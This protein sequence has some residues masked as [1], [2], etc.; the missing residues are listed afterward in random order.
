MD[1]KRFDS[2]VEGRKNKNKTA[3]RKIISTY[4]CQFF[5]ADLIDWSIKEWGKK[6]SFER[7]N[8]EY[9]YILV[10]VDAYSRYCW[11][12]NI[13]SKTANSIIVAFEKIF[14]QNVYNIAGSIDAITLPDK[15][16]N[17]PQFLVTDEGKEFVNS[18]FKAH[19][20]YN[21]IKHIVLKGQSKAM[22]AE[23]VI[24]D[25]KM[26]LR[27]KWNEIKW[28]EWTQPFCDFYN[29]KYHSV[30]KETPYNVFVNGKLPAYT[31]N[32]LDKK[33]KEKQFELADEVRIKIFK[34]ALDKKSLKNNWSTKIYTICEIDDRYEPI[35]YKVRDD[36]GN[37]LKRKFYHFELMKE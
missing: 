18:T 23:R 22:L 26:F 1:S 31:K 12:E 32:K 10:V 24:Q 15:V 25:Y 27:G 20:D 16:Q 19:L 7:A 17:I 4:P 28:I 21:N 13:K 33:D 3:F 30:I 5:F 37:L 9:K 11:M 36:K 35:M 8:N 29:N 2:R 34:D 14:D 6:Q